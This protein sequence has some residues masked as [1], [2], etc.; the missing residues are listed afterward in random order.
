MNKSVRQWPK[1]IVCHFQKDQ[2]HWTIVSNKYSNYFRC[3]YERIS[4]TDGRTVGWMRI[5]TFGTHFTYFII[6][7][8]CTW[9]QNLLIS[10][11][12]Q[13]ICETKRF[14][15]PHLKYGC[16]MSKFICVRRGEGGIRCIRVYIYP[17]NSIKL[18]K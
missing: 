12:I 1:S 13:C 4:R 5:K 6:Y 7:L 11:V 3:K 16:G 15:S 10:F 8:C 2:Q 9:G 17:N 18:A 14:C